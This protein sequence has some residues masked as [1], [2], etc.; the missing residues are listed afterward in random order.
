[1]REM[2][3]SG[4]KWIGKIPSSWNVMPNKY[5]MKKKK[6]IC[7]VYKG[8]DILSLTMKGVI[9][10]DLDAGGKMPTSFDGYQR[11][12]PGNLLM[13]LFDIDVTPRC[14][15]LIK[16][17]GLSS[18]AYS[19]F[20]LNDMGNAEYYCYYYTMLDNDKTLLHLAK[21][22]RHSLTEDQLGAISVIVPPVQE[23]KKIA[24]F[25]DAKCS[26][27]DAL[28]ADIQTQIDILEQY[29]RSVI[30]EAVTRG[31]N[32]DVEMK[33]S[34]TPW[35]PLIPIHWKYA[36]PKALFT[37][38]L[39]RA[40][41]GDKQLTA[42]QEYGVI[43]QD[44]YMELTGTKIVTVMKDFSI[45]KHVEPNDFVISM[46]SFQGGLEYSERRGSISS[47]YVMLIP[48]NE[49]VYPPF[50][51]W[52]FKSSKYIN[53]IQSTSNLVRDGQAMRY[54]NFAQVPLFI[55]PLDEQK[56]ISEYLDEKVRKIDE[57]LKSKNNQLEILAEYKKSLIYE[58]V[59][60]KKEVPSI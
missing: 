15:G 4:L 46:R 5:L 38:R 60:G 51:R 21:N 32:P 17:V 57:I 14:I 29:K 56:Q 10:R 48:N 42:S 6:V 3:D 39:D 44:E 24:D 54:A 36:N 28:S 53:A 20:E 27:I 19:Q 50:Y 52:F 12:E 49:Y 25:L 59:T 58:Y 33:D 30:T 40:Y 11:L 16:Q 13:C 41:P 22:L 43:Y 55:I 2:K 26:E 34:G 18:P 23:Q 1:M 7:P 45:L 8:E 9:V 37:Q 31:L 35:C 47:A